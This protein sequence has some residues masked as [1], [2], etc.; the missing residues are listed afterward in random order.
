MQGAHNSSLKLQSVLK[1]LLPFTFTAMH[2]LL[3]SKP[4]SSLLIN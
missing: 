3:S 1:S 4:K 2:P